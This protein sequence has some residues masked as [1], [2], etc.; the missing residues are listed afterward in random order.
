MTSKFL[1]AVTEERVVNGWDNITPRCKVVF[2]FA[3]GRFTLVLGDE[4]HGEIERKIYTPDLRAVLFA[5]G[6]IA[7]VSRDRV[8]QVYRHPKF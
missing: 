8:I 7:T 3:N 6:D 5:N 4:R 1:D 2:N